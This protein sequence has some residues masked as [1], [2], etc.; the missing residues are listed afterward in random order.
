MVFVVN[1]FVSM[2]DNVSDNVFFV[3]VIVCE[4]DE[5]VKLGFVIF[6]ESS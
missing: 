2:V 5:L 6:K 1:E 3:D 4:V